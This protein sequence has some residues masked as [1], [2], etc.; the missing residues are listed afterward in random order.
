MYLDSSDNPITVLVN[1][2]EGAR[3]VLNIYP[4]ARE[5]GGTF[6]PTRPY[7]RGGGV[8]GQAADR[9][10]SIQEAARRAK[11]NV[12][13]YCASHRL[14]RLG[15]L[16]YEGQA[17]TIS[18]PCEEM[19]PSSSVSCAL[20]WAASLFHTSGFLSGIRQTTGCTSISQ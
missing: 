5:G 17:V 13:R 12:R 8:K 19:L 11:G 3:F 7:G 6:I 18:S 16:T 4:D 20:H 14:N 1:R 10:R 9:E 2:I 15:T